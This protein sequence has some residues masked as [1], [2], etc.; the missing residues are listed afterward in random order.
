LLWPERFGRA[1]IDSLKKS[2]G[3]YR[4]AGQLQ[5]RP[6]PAEGGIFKQHWWRFWQWHGQELPPVT[7]RKAD[8]SLFECPVVTLPDGFDEQLQSWDL[9][10]KDTKASAFVVGQVWAKKDADKFLLDQVREKLNFPKTIEAVL[11]LSTKWPQAT[12]KLVEDRAN[13]P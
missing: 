13:G 3:S 4:A 12:A 6:A 7:V 2:L 8:G 5:Q 1:E 10:F 11:N 9:A